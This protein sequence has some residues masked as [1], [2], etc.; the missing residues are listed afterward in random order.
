MKGKHCEKI[1]IERRVSTLK[2]N[3]EKKLFTQKEGDIAY[4]PLHGVENVRLSHIPSDLVIISAI[5]WVA[6][7]GREAREG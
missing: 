2:L 6:E 5:C 7:N 4:C 1:E 3:D